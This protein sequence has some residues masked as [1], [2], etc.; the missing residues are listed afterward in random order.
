MFIIKNNKKL[1]ISFRNLFIFCWV[2]TCFLLIYNDI[3]NNFLP[4]W[5]SL[6]PMILFSIVVGIGVIVLLLLTIII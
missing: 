5:V 3:Q 6:L 1:E 4:L 2:I